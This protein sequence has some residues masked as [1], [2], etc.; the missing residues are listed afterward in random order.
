MNRTSQWRSLIDR[1]LARLRLGPLEREI[2]I[3]LRLRRRGRDKRQQAA[4]LGART[5][6][7]HRVE[8]LKR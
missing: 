1:L 7:Q 5:K 2:D 3:A 6:F 8:G 4:C